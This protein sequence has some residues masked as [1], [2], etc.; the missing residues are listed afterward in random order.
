M[1]GGTS[2]DDAV[3]GEAA[4]SPRV[5]LMSIEGAS[6]RLVSSSSTAVTATLA[7]T[8]SLSESEEDDERAAES[9]ADDEEISP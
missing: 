1:G 7:I 9:A 6:G 8:E 3:V 2:A 4:L 5:S